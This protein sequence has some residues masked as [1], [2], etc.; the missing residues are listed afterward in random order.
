MRQDCG[1]VSRRKR[2][3][4]KVENKMQ[5][6]MI[7]MKELLEIVPVAKPTI[8]N[9]I[10]RGLFPKPEKLGRSSFW[11]LSDV[12]KCFGRDLNG[13]ALEPAAHQDNPPTTA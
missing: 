12:K 9:Y 11:W 10:N 6:R 1:A 4:E 5:D 8:Y 3:R 7:R 13:S 2:S